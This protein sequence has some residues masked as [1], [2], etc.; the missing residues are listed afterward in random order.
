MANVEVLRV[1][2]P[3]TIAPVPRVVL[4]SLR[5]T[6]PV[7]PDGVRVAVKVTDEP[8]ADGFMDERKAVLVLALFTTC[9]SAE[10]ALLL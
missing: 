4:P 2:T 3:L 5:V 8:T 9:V 1:A 10:D 7:A 6:D